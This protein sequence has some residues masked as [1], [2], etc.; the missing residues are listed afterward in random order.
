MVSL[1]KQ[2]PGYDKD[3]LSK[4]IEYNNKHW[5]YSLGVRILQEGNY[6]Y[7]WAMNNGDAGFEFHRLQPTFK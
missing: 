7:G 2:P 5:R 4:Q 6:L 3:K 1:D